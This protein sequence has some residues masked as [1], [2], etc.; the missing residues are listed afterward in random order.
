MGV[1]TEDETAFAFEGNWKEFAPIAFS[2]MFLN[3]VTLGFYRFWATTRERQYFWGKTRFIDDKFEWTG[4]GIELF[5]GFLIALALFGLPFLLLNLVLQG[6]IFQNQQMIAGTL[7]GVS[8]VLLIYLAGVAIFRGLRY[9]LSRTYWHGIHG[10]CD[11]NGLVYGWSY[12]WKSVVAYLCMALLFPWSM[13]SL[14]KQRW[15]AMS[16]G[17]HRFE[18]NPQWGSLMGRYVIAY[19]SPFIAIIAAMIVMIP[20]ISAAAMGGGLEDGK[21]PTSFIVGIIAAVA[22]FYLVMPLLALVFYSTYMREVIGTMKLSTLEFDFTARTKEWIKLFLGNFGIWL[23]AG[24]VAAI[25]IGALGLFN[26]F[27]DLNPGENAMTSNPI[28]YIAFFVLLLIPFSVVGPFIRYRNWKFF[29][30]HLEAG[31]EV[32]LA[33]LTQSDTRELKQGEGLLDAFD[34]GAM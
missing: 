23:L 15:E 5:Y 11:D 6:L 34:M 32:N 4:K 1:G 26:Q 13:T 25:P 28:A 16:F 12:I 10:G 33:T 30:R 17:P 20:M 31:G 27:A 24:L 29:V 9:R 21:M 8:Y 2:N 14:W 3:F 18:S 19:L 7:I 22:I